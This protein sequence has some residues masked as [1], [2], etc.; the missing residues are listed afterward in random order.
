MKN[1]KLKAMLLLAVLLCSGISALAD[2]AIWQD[3]IEY[4]LLDDLTAY[5]SGAK[6]DIKTANIPEKITYEK[7]DYTVTSIR[8][9]AFS[10]S[11]LASVVI[12]SSVTR[13]EDYAFEGCSSLAYRLNSD[14]T[15]YVYDAGNLILTANI[16][17]K[18]TYEN[19]DYTVTSIG[20]CAFYSCSSLHSI[21][22]GSGV[23][24]IDET[25]FALTIKYSNGR[26]YYTYIRPEKAIWLG[27]TPPEGYE[28]V[29]GEYNYVSNDSFTDLS[30]TKVYPFLSSMFEKDGIRYVPNP[31][32]RTCDAI[33][34]AYDSTAANINIG[35]T[36]NYKGVELAVKDIR[37]YTCYGNGYVKSVKVD[38][39]GAVPIC[40]FYGCESIVS[41]DIAATNLDKISEL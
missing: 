40:A 27:N 2:T 10:Y 18:I 13:I 17:E 5:V 7:K 19:K 3:G 9:Y 28:Y 14:Y 37:P 20:N 4:W 1:F 35:K 23:Q 6:T 24:S 33:D 12:P 29:K 16:P 38:Y 22:I 39:G 34:C 11:S 21:T 36:V 31:S 30:N 25:A 8:N 15:A 26:A 41:A 32:E